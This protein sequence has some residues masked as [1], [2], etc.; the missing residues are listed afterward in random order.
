M[1]S[2]STG[3]QGNRYRKQFR[4]G[5]ALISACLPSER[6]VQLVITGSSSPFV[7]CFEVHGPIDVECSLPSCRRP[8]ELLEVHPIAGMVEAKYQSSKITIAHRTSLAQNWKIMPAR[9]CRARAERQRSVPA[10]RN[11]RNVMKYVN[12]LISTFKLLL[13]S[14]A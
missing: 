11:R 9:H 10:G 12:P 5:L 1:C 13:I 4:E 6:P 8:A 14:T 3:G 2:L 7:Y